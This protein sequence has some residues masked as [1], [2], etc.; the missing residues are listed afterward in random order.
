MM[1]QTSISSLIQSVGD[2]S[3]S[4]VIQSVNTVLSENIRRLNE[5]KYMTLT[6][7]R[8]TPDGCFTYS[9]MHQDLLIYRAAGKKVVALETHGTWIGVIPDM[10]DPSA[11]GEDE[12]QLEKGDSLL[13][14]TDGVTEAQ[15]TDGDMFGNDRLTSLLTWYGHLAAEAIKEKILT[16]VRAFM[17]VQ[18]DDLTLLVVKRK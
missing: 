8:A 4:E 18:D 15:N 2:I 11:L 12:F 6:L 5:F 1:A 3:P 17:N 13:L 14:Y 10:S 16:E 9:G 7:L